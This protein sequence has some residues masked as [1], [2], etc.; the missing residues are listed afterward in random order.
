MGLAIFGAEYA[1]GVENEYTGFRRQAG[2]D[3]SS[4]G[5]SKPA[6]GVS[7]EI[8]RVQ[9]SVGNVAAAIQDGVGVQFLF[10]HC[11]S[12]ITVQG[13]ALPEV[14]ALVA[15]EAFVEFSP[16]D[17]HH[18]ERTF[19]TNPRTFGVMRSLRNALVVSSLQF[20]SSRLPSLFE[21]VSCNMKNLCTLC[22]VSD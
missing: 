22:C 4:V 2:E 14:I 21:A 13:D 10:G 19:D 6:P 16:G 5:S 15:F 18:V 17:W 11:H 8:L 12:Q 7:G 3:V 9:G 1:C 20:V